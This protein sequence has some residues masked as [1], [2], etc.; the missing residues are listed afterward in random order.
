MKTLKTT[1]FVSALLMLA[2]VV[3]GA[4]LGIARDSARGEG[5]PWLL[6]GLVAWGAWALLDK[7]TGKKR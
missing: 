1:L 3:A 2:A 4:L 6:W 7:F 5:L